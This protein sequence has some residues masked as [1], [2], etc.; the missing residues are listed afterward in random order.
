M[1][2]LS[3]NL[4]AKFVNS[5]INIYRIFVI[6]KNVNNYKVLNNLGEILAD[7]V[8]DATVKETKCCK[9]KQTRKLRCKR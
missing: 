3:K 7:H 1:K 8:W 6:A 9:M 4:K 2:F 5:D